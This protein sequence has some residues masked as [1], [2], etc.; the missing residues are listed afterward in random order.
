[1]IMYIFNN[2][3]WCFPYL[4]SRAVSLLV[5]ENLCKYIKK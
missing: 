5:S 4:V 3:F 1:M 2:I